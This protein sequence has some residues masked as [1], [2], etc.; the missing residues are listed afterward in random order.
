MKRWVFILTAASF[1]SL[2]I[3]IGLRASVVLH[4]KAYL[5]GTMHS[6]VEFYMQSEEFSDCVKRGR[7][8]I[9]GAWEFKKISKKKPIYIIREAN[10]K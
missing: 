3:G 9:N 1:L 2:G 4:D 8:F 6:S 10:G 7:S 5:E